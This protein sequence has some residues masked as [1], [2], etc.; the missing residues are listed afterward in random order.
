M[1]LNDEDINDIK[2]IAEEVKS[3]AIKAEYRD[4]K[5]AEFAYDVDMSMRVILEII[6]G[7]SGGIEKIVERNV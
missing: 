3:M 4:G 7:P 5:F 6:N 2:T 1:I